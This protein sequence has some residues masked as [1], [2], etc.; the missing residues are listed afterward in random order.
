MCIC[1]V[2]C[3][4]GLQAWVGDLPKVRLVE[5]GEY[6]YLLRMILSFK[7]FVFQSLVSFLLLR[8]CKWFL[9]EFLYHDVDV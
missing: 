5:S 2:K 7:C 8:K 9:N 6:L 4:D 3:S 1:N